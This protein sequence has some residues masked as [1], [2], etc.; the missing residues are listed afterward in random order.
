MIAAAEAQGVTLMVGYMKR[1]DPG[2]KYAQ[3]IF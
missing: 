3:R 2:Y 1:Y